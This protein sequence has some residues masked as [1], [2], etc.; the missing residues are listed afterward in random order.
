[1]KYVKNESELI[2]IKK[3]KDMLSKRLKSIEY[4]RDDLSKKYKTIMA[5]KSSIAQV[6]DTKV[7]YIYFLYFSIIFD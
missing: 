5:D 1:M 6:L 3:E 2:S 7:R 4:E